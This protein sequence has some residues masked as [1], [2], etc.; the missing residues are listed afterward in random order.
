MQNPPRY[1]LARLEIIWWLIT[2]VI[3]TVILMPILYQL[4]DYQFFWSNLA[5]ILVFITF[6]R[7]IFLLRYSFLANWSYVKVAIIFACFIAI[8]LLVQEINFFQTFLDENGMEPIVESLPKGD[9]LNMMNYI[10]SEMLLFGV[11]SVI[12]CVVLPLRL[13]VSIWRRINGHED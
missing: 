8:F 7:Y 3:A 6:T 10:R 12:S 9:Q 5:F 4:P 2:L 13:V 1:L 11:G